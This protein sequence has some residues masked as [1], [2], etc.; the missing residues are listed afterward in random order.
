MVWPCCRLATPLPPS[1][2]HFHALRFTY[3]ARKAGCNGVEHGLAVLPRCKALVTGG[4]DGK[5]SIQIR[6]LVVHEGLRA[7]Q[8]TI[9]SQ[10]EFWQVVHGRDDSY[11]IR[12]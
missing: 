5:D 6:Q 3:K 2:E 9:L 8:S 12:L 7:A 11:V 10:T 4:K 1:T